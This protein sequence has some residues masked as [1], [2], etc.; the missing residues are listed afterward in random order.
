MC[1]STT[2]LKRPECQELVPLS[3]RP[4]A[5]MHGIS[6]GSCKKLQVINLPLEH[7]A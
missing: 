7:D 3:Y 1:K 4:E 5:Q 6:I 2:D